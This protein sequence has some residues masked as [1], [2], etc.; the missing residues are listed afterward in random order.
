MSTT[1]EDAISDEVASGEQLT[2]G[3]P[4]TNELEESATQVIIKA[5]NLIAR[6][7][8]LLGDGNSVQWDTLLESPEEIGTH[9]IKPAHFLP[10]TS[11]LSVKNDTGTSNPGDSFTCLAG[12]QHIAAL[13]L[14]DKALA[15]VT[16]SSTP[17]GVEKPSAG[18]ALAAPHITANE[19]SRLGTVVAAAAT[20]AAAMT[21]S[22]AKKLNTRVAL[23]ASGQASFSKASEKIA[24]TAIAPVPRVGSHVP[25]IDAVQD[26]EGKTIRVASVPR[27]YYGIYS[28]I[29]PGTPRP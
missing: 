25:E 17:A 16:D 24:A 9:H 27:F 21:R 11:S 4:V 19:V 10:R 23:I 18:Q 2:Q 8:S 15:L 3:L 7:Q 5:L 26:T 20:D 14:F 13:S 6:A 12:G 22:Q 28:V 29:Y 1:I